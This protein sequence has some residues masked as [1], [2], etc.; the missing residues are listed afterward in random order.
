MVRQS[1]V[2]KLALADK[3]VVNGE[4]LLERCVRVGK[5]S[6]VEVDA[7]CAQSAQALLDLLNG[8]AAGEA[9]VRVEAA[10]T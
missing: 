6:V 3:V 10:L 8:V 4:G 9:G 1:D 7:V 2:A 5:V